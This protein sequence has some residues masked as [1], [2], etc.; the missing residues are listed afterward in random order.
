MTQ[1]EPWTVRHLYSTADRKFGPYLQRMRQLLDQA[2]QAGWIYERH[3]V[4]LSEDSQILPAFAEIGFGE[5]VIVDL[6][7]W[8][9]DDEPACLGTEA[10]GPYA[11]LADLDARSC[12]PSAFV[13]GNCRGAREQFN[14]AIGRIICDPAAIIGHFDEA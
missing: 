13:L 3:D 6:H 10:D 14:Q 2:E 1:A 12:R 8:A 9:D 4:P 11:R 7:G 5:L